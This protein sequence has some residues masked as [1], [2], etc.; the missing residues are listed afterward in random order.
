MKKYLFAICIII[1]TV[2][3]TCNPVIAQ[4]FFWS[5]QIGSNS[6]DYGRS[7]ACDNDGNFYYA[8]VFEGPYCYFQ[9]DTLVRHGIND[10][11]L[12]KYG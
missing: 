4:S 8:G 11:F 7:G 12:V 5:N 6:A 2:I 3:I 1:L 10:L 9:T